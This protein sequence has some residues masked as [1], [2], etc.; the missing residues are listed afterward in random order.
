[1][2]DLAALG[3]ALWPVMT[4]PPSAGYEVITEASVGRRGGDAFGWQG[5]GGARGSPAPRA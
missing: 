5:S 3:V 1:L 2:S 4:R